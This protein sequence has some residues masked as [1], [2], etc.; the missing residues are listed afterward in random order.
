MFACIRYTDDPDK[1]CIINTNLIK[2][3]NVEDYNSTQVY[4]AWWEPS[5]SNKKCAGPSGYYK[6]QVL[7]IKGIVNLQKIKILLQNTLQLLNDIIMY[8]L[9]QK[10]LCKNKLI[11]G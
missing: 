3:F 2:D 4:E 1:K 7:L 6:C 9:M 11:G 8:I 10:S 5:T